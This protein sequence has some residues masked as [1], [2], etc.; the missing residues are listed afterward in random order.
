MKRLK[1][2][3]G[4]KYGRLVV[5]EEADITIK[6]KQNHLGT[7]KTKELAVEARNNYIIQSK[8]QSDYTIQELI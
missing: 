3:V 2:L 1:T 6:G 7:H 4:D 5:I 8:L